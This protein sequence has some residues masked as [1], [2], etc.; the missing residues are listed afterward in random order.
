M[1]I[2][3]DEETKKLMDNIFQ[4]WLLWQPERNQQQIQFPFAL[5]SIK[6]N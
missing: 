1:I 3:L 6:P 4:E 2:I 5:P